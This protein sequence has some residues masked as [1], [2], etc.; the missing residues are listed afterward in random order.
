MPRTF[1]LAAAPAFRRD[2]PQNNLLESANWAGQKALDLYLADLA[3]TA[4]LAHEE[5]RALSA[6]IQTAERVLFG[7]IVAAGIALPELD[8]LLQGLKRHEVTPEEVVDTLE[9]AQPSRQELVRWLEA[10][11]TPR[12][13]RRSLRHRDQ[14]SR[15]TRRGAFGHL[16]LARHLVEPILQRVASALLELDDVEAGLEAAMLDAAALASRVRDRRDLGALHAAQ[17][18]VV[19]QRERVAAVARS[20]GTSPSRLRAA[21][22]RI[23]AAEARLRSAK[24]ELLRAN[25]RLVVMFAKKYR[26]RGVAFDDLIQEGNI[27]LMRAVDKYDHRVGTRFSTYAAWWVQ[28]AVQRAIIAQGSD[29]R[30]PV[31]LSATRSRIGRAE[32]TLAGRLGYEPDAAET[33]RAMG[34]DVFDVLKSRAVSATTVSVD[35][36]LGEEGRSFGETLADERGEAADDAVARGSRERE[37]H[38]LLATLTPKEQVVLRLRFGLDGCR[39]HTLR[40]IGQQMKV[41]RERI[42]QIESKA[43]QKLRDAS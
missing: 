11:V 19:E 23:R 39:V 8:E 9:A 28:Q 20:L 38:E 32:Q 4:P 24:D 36:S 18:A 6:A 1:R 26:G 31:H 7:A 10:V 29:I 25:L 40:E 41:S 13:S 34:I 22:P 3:H 2:K 16:P 21:R 43:L 30:L 12:A 33:A 42:R 14:R 15:R 27:G 37:A 17:T 35:G 5:E